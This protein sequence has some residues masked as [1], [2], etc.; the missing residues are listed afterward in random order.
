V[1]TSRVVDPGF[2][3]DLVKPTATNLLVFVASLL[4]MQH[5]GEKDWLAQNW[6]NVS[7]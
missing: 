2:E 3:P 1:L 4:I 5:L 6:D 7:E